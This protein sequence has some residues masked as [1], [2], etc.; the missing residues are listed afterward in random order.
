GRRRSRARGTTS[1]ARRRGRSAG[2]WSSSASS[3]LL[4]LEEEPAEAAEVESV[5]ELEA[6]SGRG[7]DEAVCVD[8]LRTRV[9]EREAEVH[10]L[11]VEAAAAQVGVADAQPAAGLQDAGDVPE[12]A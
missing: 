6:A 8:R 9:A 12:H 7:R 10:Q 3:R 1:A 4:S 5:G 11:L 2:A